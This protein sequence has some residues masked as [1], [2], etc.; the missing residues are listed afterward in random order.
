MYI[1]TQ[2]KTHPYIYIY[3]VPDVNALEPSASA[4]VHWPKFSKVSS[5]V[6]CYVKFSHVFVFEN[7]YLARFSN[8]RGDSGLMDDSASCIYAHIYTHT[9]TH[10]YIYM[11][12]YIYIRI[13]IYFN[14]R[15]YK[16]T[17]IYIY[18]FIHI[19]IHIYIHVYRNINI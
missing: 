4:H 13:C 12:I 11:Y 8:V 10:I 6:F 2:T 9:H 16:C 17:C 18:V 7:L 3:I 14:K 15:I 5:T 1:Y 19:Y